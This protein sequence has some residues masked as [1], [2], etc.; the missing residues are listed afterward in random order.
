MTDTEVAPGTR[1]RVVRFQQDALQHLDCLYSAA[2]LMTGDPAEAEVLLQDVFATAVASLHQIRPGDN[3]KAW[4]YQIMFTVFAD[5]RD[6]VPRGAGRDVDGAAGD[7]RLTVPGPQSRAS[8]RSTTA[9]ALDRLSPRHVRAAVR[10]LPNDLRIA[11][12]LADVEG[13]SYREI[14]E[15]TGVPI[16]DAIRNLHS[17]RRELRTRLQHAVDAA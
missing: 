11:V 8:P 12:Y 3:L 6:G 1:Q 4:L 7:R 14:A 17:A 13:F 5:S 16:G 10:S 2:L 15:I 9:D